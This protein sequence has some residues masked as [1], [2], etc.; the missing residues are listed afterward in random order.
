M[1][2]KVTKSIFH[3]HSRSQSFD[4]KKQ[5]QF[6][7]II[8]FVQL[9]TILS[10]ISRSSS[11]CKVLLNLKFL[12]TITGATL[13]I[14]VSHAN[15]MAGNYLYHLIAYLFVPISLFS[16]FFCKNNIDSTWTGAK[17]IAYDRRATPMCFYCQKL[18]KKQKFQC[19]EYQIQISCGFQRLHIYML[20]A[21]QIA[22][23]GCGTWRGWCIGCRLVIF[24]WQT[25]TTLTRLSRI[26]NVFFLFRWRCRM[27]VNWTPNIFVIKFHVLRAVSGARPT[28]RALCWIIL[29]LESQWDR[30]RETFF[31]RH[32]L[33]FLSVSACFI[34]LFVFGG[35]PEEMPVP[36]LSPFVLDKSEKKFQTFLSGVLFF[37]IYIWLYCFYIAY[38]YIELTSGFAWFYSAFYCLRL[39]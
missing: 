23:Y 35:N 16:P 1:K 29:G 21:S 20:F 37:F 14:R 34:I 27:A 11:D 3:D 39:V 30:P 24:V 22:I 32:S 28:P 4:K 2:L 6:G 33:A 13:F 25:G 12:W 7:G 38:L 36:I 18:K 8:Y 19:V 9:Y 5:C 15:Y 10:L 26:T 17:I 31:W